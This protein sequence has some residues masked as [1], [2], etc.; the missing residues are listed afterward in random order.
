MDAASPRRAAFEQC[1]QGE[2]RPPWVGPVV[3]GALQHPPAAPSDQLEDGWLERPAPVG[4]A[5]R[6][7][8]GPPGSV[9][10]HDQRVIGELGE[11]LRENARTDP[12]ERRL[13]VAEGAIAE[14]QLPDD[15]KGPAITDPVEGSG[16]PAELAVGLA[17]RHVVYSTIENKVEGEHM[18]RASNG[19]AYRRAGSGPT[20]VLLHGIPGQG[21]AWDHVQAALEGRF[22]VI[23][24]DLI[25]FGDSDRPST[26]TIDNV[27]PT[28]QSSH[29]ATLL[30]ELGVRHAT[31][32]GHDFGAPVSVLLASM[33]PDLVAAV[34]LLAGN[35][36]PDTPI[37]F[38]LSLTTAPII[39]G[40]FSR[41]LFSAPSLALMLR[42][43]TGPGSAPPDA[44]LYLGDRGQ[45]RTIATI[46]SGAL[47]RLAEQY[48]PVAAALQDLDV[49]VLVGWGDHDPF[50]PL[51]Q[52]ERTA[53]AADARLHV[54]DG[55]GHFLPHERPDEVAHEIATLATAVST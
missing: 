54:F 34:S 24:P 47:T 15:E 6:D 37:P 29:V 35:T 53:A 33:R 40:L 30:D 25:G 19:M 8:L 22:D 26:P 18:A 52:G 20:V 7:V 13:E 9:V 39:G 10:A 14:K 1:P 23:V 41:L 17:F 28:A 2:R 4:E 51:S 31:V 55:A 46:F 36:F 21:R 32:V 27:G 43:G 44:K 42:Q 16:Q 3:A 12:V 5:V 49:P 50:F 45:R 38:P 48:T 11:A